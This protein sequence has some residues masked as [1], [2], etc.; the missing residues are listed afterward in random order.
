M[1]LF[2]GNVASAVICHSN[3]CGAEY[4]TRHHGEGGDVS[5][6]LYCSGHKTLHLGY[7]S[8]EYDD[9]VSIAI[10]SMTVASA[11]TTSP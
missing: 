10:I 4:D 5:P 2:L 9:C 6:S 7:H 1:I 11:I 8:A 3:G